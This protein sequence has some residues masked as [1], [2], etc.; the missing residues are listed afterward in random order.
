MFVNLYKINFRLKF[1]IVCLFLLT[2][3]IN[4]NNAFSQGDLMITPR[5]VVFEGNRRSQE[6]ILANIGKDTAKYFISV[7]QIRM[8][9]NGQFEQITAP[10]SG[11]FFAD[12]YFRFF[13]RSV[14]LAPNESQTI[15]VQLSKTDKMA[16]GE[17][18]SHLFFRS[19][20]NTKALGDDNQER[21]TSVLTIRLIPVFGITIP[22]I[23]RVG[24]LNAKVTLS[25]IKMETVND[26]LQRVNML[27]SRSGNMSVYGDITVVHISDKGA[28]NTVGYVK[29]FAVYT[30]NQFRKF[31]VNL[32]NVKNVDW[33]HGKLHLIFSSE[34]SPKGAPLAEAE[35]QLN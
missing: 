13:P 14:S 26:T 6:L 25:D 21:D 8:K 10:D 9:D 16:S 31:H 33:H 15:K 30:P 23:I 27:F 20:P 28:K 32:N 4:S 12:K 7:V 17:Y 24:E 18:R 1:R 5:R 3:I 29:G 11:Q 2:S 22:V 34:S 19:E 35:L